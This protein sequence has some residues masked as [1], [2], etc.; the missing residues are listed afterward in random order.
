[1]QGFNVPVPSGAGDEEDMY[2]SST[3]RPQR[4][5]KGTAGQY[6]GSA[7]GED[8]ID[9]IVRADVVCVCVRACVC[10]L[11]GRRGGWGCQRVNVSKAVG[12]KN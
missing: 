1:V 4:R 7:L 9:R 3:G 6:A 2:M 12:C 11:G 5:S 8:D 10:V